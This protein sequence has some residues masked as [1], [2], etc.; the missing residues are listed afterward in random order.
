MS[1][2]GHRAPP[3]VGFAPR[4]GAPAGGRSG[5]SAKL[6]PGEELDMAA[7]GKDRAALVAVQAPDPFGVIWEIGGVVKI[8]CAGVS[9]AEVVFIRFPQH[10]AHRAPGSTAL[11]GELAAAILLALTADRAVHDV[12]GDPVKA[13]QISA[14]RATR[15]GLA[16]DVHRAKIDLRIGQISKPE[17]GLVGGELVR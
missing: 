8:K 1:V 7:D 17:T 16:L 3:Q 11:D 13:G 5:I 10:V 9:R 2:G 15:V 14:V 6:R 12:A 4:S